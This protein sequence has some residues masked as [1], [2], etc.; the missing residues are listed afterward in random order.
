MSAVAQTMT[1]DV[2]VLV[3]ASRSDHPHHGTARIWLEK[4][5]AIV[6]NQGAPLPSTAAKIRH[7][8]LWDIAWL[9]T[10][11]AELDPRMVAGKIGDYGIPNFPELL[12]RALEMIPA[13]VKSAAFKDPMRRFIDAGTVKRTLGDERYL[14]YLASTVGGQFQETKAH[15]QHAAAPEA[16][17]AVAAPGQ[18]PKPKKSAPSAD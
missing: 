13:V 18:V 1:P 17:K 2:N 9:L 14:D 7:R 16:A 15:L 4:S 11:R 5:I 3:A 8:D 6:D 10:K 12:D